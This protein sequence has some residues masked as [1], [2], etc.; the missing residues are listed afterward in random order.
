MTTID[1]FFAVENSPIVKALKNSQHRSPIMRA[2]RGLSTPKRKPVRRAPGRG[3][4][5]P[6]EQQFALEG[7]MQPGTESQFC[8]NGKDFFITHDTWIVGEIEPGAYASVRGPLRAGKRIATKL[9][10]IKPKGAT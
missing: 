4:A 3:T 2:I 5:K 10:I 7:L 6:A 1:E 8:I 9:V